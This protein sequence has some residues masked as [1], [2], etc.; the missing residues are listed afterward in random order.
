MGIE[1]YIEVEEKEFDWNKKC[2]GTYVLKN[3]RIPVQFSHFDLNFIIYYEKYN[4]TV[5]KWVSFVSPAM[6]K[7]EKELNDTMEVSKDP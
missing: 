3:A 1:G 2:K 7:L 4:L 5:S 6:E